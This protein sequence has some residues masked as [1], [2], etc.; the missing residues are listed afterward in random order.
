MWFTKIQHSGSDSPPMSRTQTPAAARAEVDD[1]YWRTLHNRLSFTSQEQQLPS[2]M[3]L[4]TCVRLYFLRFHAIF[5]I[6]HAPTFRPSRANARLV[7][8][9]C[10]IGCLY[11]GAPDAPKLSS[12]L[13]ESL[14]K[15]SMSKWEAVLTGDFEEAVAMVHSALLGQMFALLSGDGRHLAQ[16]DALSGAVI[17]WARRCKLFSACHTPLDVANLSEEALN[18]AWHSWIRTETHVRACTGLYIHDAEVASIFHHEPILRHDK[19]QLSRPSFDSMFMAA[20]A[21]EWRQQA[22]QYAHHESLDPRSPLTEDAAFFTVSPQ[23]LFA[24]YQVL[25]DIIAIIMDKRLNEQL[26]ALAKNNIMHRL[27]SA[28]Q[29]FFATSL[30]KSNSFDLHILWHLAFMTLYTDTDLLER[31]IGRD[32]LIDQLSAARVQR[33]AES[34][35]AIRCAIHGALIIQILESLSLKHEPA[36]HTPRATF[37]AGI[38]WY[39]YAVYAPPDHVATTQDPTVP[40]FPEFKLLGINEQSLLFE[41]QGFSHGRPIS[42]GTNGVLCG[43]AD[44]LRR[45]GH[46]GISKRL[47]SILSEIIHTGPT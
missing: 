40:S 34:L 7:L 5:P 18:V 44:I 20:N 37:F 35:D 46:S 43:A 1:N 32:G 10:A 36:L 47:S 14:Q 45:I 41:A 8:S 24:T 29:Q 26:D 30:S 21:E 19:R 33:W 25:E 42:P 31:A 2:T 9:I 13:F 16:L 6:F 11:T 4:N 17:S 23:R 39:C 27:L 3:F 12:Q 38:I 28:H 22:L 15:S